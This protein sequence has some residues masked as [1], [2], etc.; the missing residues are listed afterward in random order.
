MAVNLWLVS[1]VLKQLILTISARVLIA[2]MEERIFRGAFSTI[3]G[4]V[5]LSSASSCVLDVQ[6]G[7]SRDL[8]ESTF[9]PYCLPKKWVSDTQDAG[10]FSYSKVSLFSHFWRLLALLKT[11]SLKLW[12]CV[13]FKNSLWNTG[14]KVMASSIFLSLSFFI[15][16]NISPELTTANPPLF[17]E[18]DW[19]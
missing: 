8:R 11:R 7:T 18:E 10:R 1:R 4:A 15:L 12:F 3:F 2:L 9:Y 19:P 13:H 16:R 14:K 17:A 5:V 6:W